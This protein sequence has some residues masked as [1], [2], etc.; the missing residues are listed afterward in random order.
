MENV[1]VQQQLDFMRTQMEQQAM[2][3]QKLHGDAATRIAR[4]SDEVA[5]LAPDIAQAI[6]PH[7]QLAPAETTERKRILNTYPKVHLPKVLRDDNGLA[8]QAI[9]QDSAAKKLVLE[10][11]P[12]IQRD[13]LDV[14]RVAASA[15]QQGRYMVQQQDPGGALA[16]LYDALRDIISLSCDSA[17]R[18]AQAQLKQTLD[19][20]GHS[21]A[22]SL[23]DLS[24]D[25]QQLDFDDCNILQPSHLEALM[26]IKQFK[27][28]ITATRVSKP[29]GG[30]GRGN[31]DRG[32]GGGRG[33]GYSGGKG[34]GSGRGGGYGKGKGGKGSGNASPSQAAPSPMQP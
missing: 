26:E 32:K 7:L 13:N 18:A 28:T 23:I 16:F 6:A 12:A 11:L 27:A 20:A 4:R 14:V 17:Q 24:P 25:T 1:S 8:A 9:G 2:Q 31:N 10:R 3:L 29:Q 5:E 22:Y 33:N 30:G 15:W 21:G 19:S 34:K